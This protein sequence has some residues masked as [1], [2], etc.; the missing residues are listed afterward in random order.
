MN[1]VIDNKLPKNLLQTAI[2][3]YCQ[4]ESCRL[5]AIFGVRF[6]RFDMRRALVTK[7]LHTKS[8]F[9]IT[10]SCRQLFLQSVE[11]LILVTEH[12]RAKM[13]KKRRGGGV[14]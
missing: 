2:Q 13:G 8:K 1:Q 11:A 10:N 14:T 7:L 4:R 3:F 5:Y 12:I 6:Q 9:L